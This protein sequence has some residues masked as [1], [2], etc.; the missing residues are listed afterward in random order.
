MS[1]NSKNRAIRLAVLASW[2]AAWACAQSFT[3]QPVVT[4]LSHSTA[5]VTFIVSSAPSN[6]D[7]QWSTDLSFSNSASVAVNTPA[8]VTG[9]AVLVSLAPGTTYNLR[10]RLNAGAVVSNTIQ[11]TTPPEPAIHP[12]QPMAPAAVDVSM[13]PAAPNASEYH[14]S[15]NPSGRRITVAADCSD[16]GTKTGW[17]SALPATSDTFEVV[18]P[19]GTLC[20]GQFTF[21]AR[22]NHAGWVVVRSSAAGTSVFP[23]EGVRWTPNWP[24]AATLATFQTNALVYNIP[25]YA[26]YSWKDRTDCGMDGEDGLMAIY[27][28]T[29]ETGVL[30]LLR[31]SSAYAPYAGPNAITNIVG[32]TPFTITA[33]GNTVSNG[34]VIRITAN[35]LLSPDRAYV[36]F[37]KSGDTFQVT[38]NGVIGGGSFNAGLN[39]VFT[40]QPV[41]KVLPHT[42]AAADPSGG[43]TAGAFHWNTSAQ[44]LW[45]CRDD[46]WQRYN[47][48]SFTNSSELQAAITVGANARRYRFIG[49]EVRPKRYPAPLPAGW[50]TVTPAGSAYQASV[51]HLMYVS[52]GASEIVVDRSYL[53]GLE[54][55]H[56]LRYAVS[57]YLKNSAVISSYIDEVAW[58]RASG[59]SQTESSGGINLW[60]ESR[61]FLSHN[62]YI[63][64]AGIHLFAPDQGVTGPMPGDIAVTRNTFKQYPKWRRGDPANADVN[65]THRNQ[66][67]CK[68]CERLKIEG[69]V[70]DYGYSSL[71]AGQ[72]VLMTPRCG[73][74]TMT[75]ASIAS[76]NGGVL[77]TTAA[78]G[79]YPGSVVYVTGTGSA[80]DGLWEVASTNCPGACTQLTL[81]GNVTGS[82]SGGSV[83]MRQTHKG[84][85]DV[86]IRNNLFYQG[87]ETLRVAG[88]DAACSNTRLIP[89]QRVALVNNLVVDTDIRSF[90]TG[91]RVDQFGTFAAGDFGARSVYI[92]GNVEDVTVANNTFYAQRGNMPFLLYAEQGN[93]GLDLR[94]NLYQW[95]GFGGLTAMGGNTGT[96]VWGNAGLD[97]TWRRG[98][99]PSHNVKNNVICCGLSANAA[100]HPATTRWPATEDAVRWMK[101]GPASPFEFRLRHDSPY[102]SAGA[103]RSTEDRDTGVNADE[104]EQRTGRV[105]NVRARAVAASSAVV[106]Y[107]APDAAACTVEYGTSPVWGTGTRIGDGGGARVRNVPVASLSPGTIYHYRVL[108]EVE[109]PSGW[110]R[111]P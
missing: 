43:C 2:G 34:D 92:M 85:R 88:S 70:F 87:V 76:F 99:A 54:H 19:A 64:V 45:W 103:H 72:F 24:A 98:G 90:A 89:T 100:N 111:T 82:G 58:W 66:I 78:H 31:C 22:A 51:S 33:P 9:S 23:P 40:L 27:Q 28:F 12:A 106:S 14:P 55:P 6:A 104:L 3:V 42:A 75:A 68:Q 73:S 56:R 63:A 21:P 97:G 52:S 81:L 15:T 94:N 29:M 109:Q 26:D 62:N 60:N 80:H 30:G 67:E 102:I 7:V 47:L 59:Y 71:T 38:P 96:P 95:N 86:D 65:F 32:P 16:L 36:V 61:G 8:P 53:R 107:L 10:A 13:P 44:R 37:N 5:R 48:F 77:T 84:I 35:G 83:Q 110:F 20:D 11:F 25:Y 41:Y 50:M 74:T 93:E 4:N 17:L 57:G 1:S 18:I 91:G 101:P 79:F 108:C 49:L 69:N 39:P 105:R 46:G